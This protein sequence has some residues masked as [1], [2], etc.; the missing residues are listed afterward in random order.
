MQA[1]AAQ[2]EKVVVQGQ[3]PGGGGFQFFPIQVGPCTPY[4]RSRR[5]AFGC[6]LLYQLLMGLMAM[7]EFKN[8]LSGIIMCFGVLAGLFAFKEDMNVTYI[9]WWGVLCFAGFIAGVV[10]AFI[11]FAVMISTIVLK[12]NVPMSCF[13]GMVL[14]WWIYADYEGEHPESN[15]MVASWLR[16]FGLLKPKVFPAPTMPGISNTLLSK[17][18]LPVFGNVDAMKAQANEQYNQAAAIYPGYKDQAMAQANSY[19]AM[20]R[21]NLAAAQAAGQAQ[22]EQG[23]GGWF[24]SKAAA[25]PPVPV[26]PGAPAAAPPVQPRDVRRDPFLTQ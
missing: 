8:F 13:F 21:E 4:A 10:A 20:G 7:I 24:A 9:C 12:F 25:A 17:G 14:A 3:V 2:M 19:G 15:D 5:L 23:Y 16:A 26:A 11:G 22:A 1:S 6:I 18:Q